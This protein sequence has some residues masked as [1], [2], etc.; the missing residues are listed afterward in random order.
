MLTRCSAYDNWND[1][2]PQDFA[3]AMDYAVDTSAYAALLEGDSRA[4]IDGYAMTYPAEDRAR[5]FECACNPGNESLFASPIMR[6][7]LL[8]VCTGIRQ[9]F[10]L[11]T[12]SGPYLWEQYLSS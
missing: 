7:K 3:Y 2:N 10:G 1:L 5:I 8:R 9:A 12:D 4:F 11:P 6:Q